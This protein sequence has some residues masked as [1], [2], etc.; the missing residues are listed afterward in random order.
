MKKSFVSFGAVKT[1]GFC[2]LALLLSSCASLPTTPVHTMPPGAPGTAPVIRCD[3]YHVVGPGETIYRIGKMYDVSA[4]DIL[5]AN[6]ITDPRKLRVGQKILVPAA[7]KLRPAIPLFKSHKWKYIVVHHSA[8]DSGDANFLDYIHRRRGF[9]RGL[10]YHFVIDNGTTSC[11]EDGQI[12]PSRRWIKQ[13]DGAHCNAAGM[14]KKGIGICLVGDFT[15]TV[16]TKK[17]MDSLVYLVNILRKQYN[18]PLTHIIG[19][20][21]VPGK[22]TEC[23]GK[24]FP[25]KEFMRRLRN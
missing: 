4:S 6:R 21:D 9:S 8:T 25:W 16:P 15:D 10:G 24:N 1:F 22:A 19:H 17:Q 5:R 20:R 7:G 18:I 2:I 14:N 13:Q 11:R 23:P 12:E 3:L